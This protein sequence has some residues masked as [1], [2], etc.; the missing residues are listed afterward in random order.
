MRA[1]SVTNPRPFRPRVPPVPTSRECTPGEDGSHG[2]SVTLLHEHALLREALVAKELRV[3]ALHRHLLEA[4]RLLDPVAVRLAV[5][6]VV[7]VVLGLGHGVCKY[8]PRG[9][10][11]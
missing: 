4:L 7:R 9:A 1:L 11:E 5:L 2:I 8:Q 6:V 3:H 10:L